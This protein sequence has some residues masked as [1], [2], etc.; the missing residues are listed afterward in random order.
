MS[1]Q[2]SELYEILKFNGD[3][4]KN[5][6]KLIGADLYPSSV[7]AVRGPSFWRTVM[8]AVVSTRLTWLQK[9]GFSWLHALSPY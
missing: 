3:F 6:E 9:Y 5:Y 8:V 2:S 1:D 7:K 4:K